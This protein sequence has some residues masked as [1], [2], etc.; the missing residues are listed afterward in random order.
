MSEAGPRI[1]IC[2]CEGTLP[3]DEAGLRRAC[4]AALGEST[5]GFDGKPAH[6][7]C[8]IDAGRVQAALLAGAADGRPLAIGCT[9]ETLLFE[10]IR[11]DAGVETPIHSFNI[12]ELAGW[13]SEGAVA[14]AKQ[15]AL[16]ALARDDAMTAHRNQPEPLTL[17]LE[18]QGIV[19]VYGRDEVALEVAQRLLGTLDVTVLLT[20]PG[21][22]APPRTGDVPVYRGTI[23]RATGHFGAFQLVVDDYAQPLP[24]SRSVLGFG[25]PRNGAKS[26]CDAILDLSGGPA[27]FA[28]RDG[29]L[30]AD[31]RDPVAVAR[32]VVEATGLTGIFEKPRYV[33]LDEGRCAHARSQKTG[34]TRCL[35]VCPTGAIT[36]KGDAVAVDPA[37][38]MGCGSCAAVCPTEAVTYT[39]PPAASDY[40]RL[41][42]LLT[43]YRQ[44]AASEPGSTPAPVLLLHDRAHG[45]P[46]IEALARYGDG[47]PA[48]VLPLSV[49]EISLIGVELLVSALAYGAASIVLL[50]TR[51]NAGELSALAQQIGLAETLASGLGYGSG[52]VTLVEADDPDRLAEALMQG[53]TLA[54]IS[55]EPTGLAAGF[56]PLGGKRSVTR[57]ALTALAAAA[58]TPRDTLALPPGAPF[59]AVQVDAAGCT[60]CLSCV[61]ACPTGAL[62]DDPDFPRL[63]FVEDAC[64][65]CGLCKATCPE[66]VITLEPRYVFTDAA[67]APRVLKEEEPALCI[68][69]G[70]AFGVKSTIDRIHAQLAGKHAMFA[71]SVAAD[72]IRMCADC[73]VIAEFDHKIDPY[74]AAERP[75]TRTTDD[76]LA[77]RALRDA[78]PEGTA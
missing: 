46:V 45:L 40:A 19:L 64:V 59:G 66:K 29:Y 36:P 39:A 75:P 51:A 57:L 63:S 32:L 62:R 7:L 35:S 23:S 67:K 69:C 47:L 25:A 61:P 68:R 73:R 42:T 16:I 48:R 5:G 52:R 1:L 26:T 18:S 34:C 11:A 12:R 15:A 28:K 56:L 77:D 6:A 20:R 21:E 50:A 8:R 70:T 13:S 38:C 44:A 3:V 58:P 78:K 43:A 74:A 41:R 76:Y 60:L 37:I 49:A 10:E 53:N 71:E 65:Q 54:P 33:A 24:S 31:P 17:T 4:T 14:T 9:Q 2:R 72:R 55:L 22:I 27:L 30:R